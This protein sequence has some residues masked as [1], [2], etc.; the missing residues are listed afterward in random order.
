MQT[1]SGELRTFSSFF[2]L[3]V[4]LPW[5]PLPTLSRVQH[6][7]PRLPPCSCQQ[8]SSCLPVAS[9]ALGPLHMW[10]YASPPPRSPAPAAWYSSFAGS[11]NSLC[12]VHLLMQGSLLYIGDHFCISEIISVYQVVV[13]RI[14]ECP[15]PVHAQ[16][17]LCT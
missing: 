2:N 15:L 14:P 11:P 8:C 3:P 6:R 13:L 10:G 4:L 1:A 16:R 5:F 12:L 7:H 17:T 9:V